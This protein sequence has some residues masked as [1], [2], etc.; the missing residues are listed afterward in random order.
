M[1]AIKL[2]VVGGPKYHRLSVRANGIVKACM[3]GLVA[4]MAKDEGKQQTKLMRAEQSTEA[5]K[6]PLALCLVCQLGPLLSRL[7]SEQR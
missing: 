4:V 2:H 6:K 3:R 1:V 7:D 5:L